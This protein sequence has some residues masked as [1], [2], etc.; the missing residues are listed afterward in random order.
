M[1]S[2]LG[3]YVNENVI[4]FAKMS[5][6]KNV[7]Q[8]EQYGT[9]FVK[10]DPLNQLEAIIQETNSSNIPVAI[11]PE[12]S[13]FINIEMF[14]QG[15]VKSY[16]N[17]VAKMEFEAW[18]EKNAKTP[19]R[20]EY[21]YKS[22]DAKNVEGKRNI[23]INV[24]E[25][26]IINKYTQ[27]FSNIS[28]LYPASLLTQRLVPSIDQ[29]YLLVDFSDSLTIVAVVNNKIVDMQSFKIGMKQILQDFSNK[30]GSYQK[31]Y[32]AC[33]QIN[34]FSEGIDNN[35]KELETL[36]EP[37]LQEVLKDVQ[38]YVDKYRRDIEKIVLTGSGIIFTNID[39][40]FTEFLDEKCEILKPEFLE[41]TSNVRNTADM[42][43][44]IEAMALAYDVL[45][46]KAKESEY[47]KKN[48]IKKGFFSVFEKKPK[49]NKIVKK[50][51]KSDLE[52]KSKDTMDVSISFFD[53]TRI[54]SLLICA[55]IVL[56]IL[57]VSYVVFG[58]IYSSRVEKMKNDINN[59]IANIDSDITDA[60]NDYG[61]ISTNMTKYKNINDE[62]QE[63]IEQ[64]ES[65]KI[66]KFSTYNVAT[67][68]QNII[69][70]IP[71]NVQ[72]VNI[73]SDDNKNVKIVAKSNSYADLGYF[74]AELKI[75]NTLNSLK[76][77]SVKNSE[78]TVVEIGGELP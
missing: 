20:Y 21:I 28:S 7:L 14:E 24:V 40:L 74:V 29:N 19:Q 62:V 30:L 36:L 26:D 57:F 23:E 38:I 54:S 4:K 73:S 42:L 75:N 70:I 68:L 65:N 64:I 12:R 9:R 46:P 34:V 22:A 48:N 2:C 16:F 37:L 17:D 45:I 5:Y 31:A 10:V 58:S 67:F 76:V 47:V 56:A 44:T 66:G 13:E 6:E 18:C 27:R 8:L 33:K 11:T 78:T 53:S 32:E 52:K 72:L 39:I 15:Q 60:N 55:C 50:E 61:Y 49:E 77:N 43:E 3:I 35:D 59:T 25:K 63:V 71:K 1:S 51:Q 41:N 69:K